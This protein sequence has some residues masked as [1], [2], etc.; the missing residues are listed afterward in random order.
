MML[1]SVACLFVCCRVIIW[2]GAGVGNKN[3]RGS[4][5][6]MERV[7]EDEGKEE[8][9]KENLVAW[10]WVGGLNSRV[11]KNDPVR[12]CCLVTLAWLAQPVYA[13]VR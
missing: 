1:L 4:S 7:K 8:K 13:F 12:V 11:K 3:V 2:R 9:R 10:K 5:E 6:R